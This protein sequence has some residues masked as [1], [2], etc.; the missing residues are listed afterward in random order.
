MP[1]LR[2]LNIWSLSSAI[3]YLVLMLS[4]CT[5]IE[6]KESDTNLEYIASKTNNYCN[7]ILH[8]SH[9][10]SINGANLEFIKKAKVNETIIST[11]SGVHQNVPH[12]TALSRYRSYSEKGVYRTDVDG[13]LALRF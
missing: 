4:G 13:T 2:C 5:G 1:S 12:P 7:D 3:F 8:A 9:H 10:G 6:K 11:Q